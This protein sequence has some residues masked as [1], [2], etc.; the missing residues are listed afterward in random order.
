M[1]ERF[2]RGA[3]TRETTSGSGLGL[4]IAR[5][6]VMACGGRIEAASEGVGCGSVVTI[7][8]PEALTVMAGAN[9]E[10]DE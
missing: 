3:R 4:W 5:A 9:G 7:V 8:L 10:P 6:F 1:F 2:Y